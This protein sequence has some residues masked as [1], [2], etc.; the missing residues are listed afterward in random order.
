M[1]RIKKNVM[2]AR[3]TLKFTKLKDNQGRRITSTQY[4][5]KAAAYQANEP[6]KIDDINLPPSKSKPLVSL[7]RTVPHQ[8]W[9]LHAA[10][11]GQSN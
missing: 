1:E 11:T 4:S 9:P 6:W 3:P 2:R 8:R 10:K 5:Q 7:A